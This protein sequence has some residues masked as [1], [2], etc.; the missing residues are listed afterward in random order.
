MNRKKR[1]EFLLKNNLKAWKLDIID[2]SLAHSGHHNFDGTQESHFQII[3][4]NNFIIK[5]SRLEI[6]QK[7]NSLLKDEFVNGLHSLEIKIDN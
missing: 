5:E 4:K 3:L 6:H 2:N 7:I 1:I